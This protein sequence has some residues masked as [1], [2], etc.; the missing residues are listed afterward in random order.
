MLLKRRRNTT[1]ENV[2]DLNSRLQES[3]SRENAYD[4][5]IRT[6]LVLVKEF[7]LDIA[8]LKTDRFYAS[9]DAFSEKF[10]S[11]Q[12]SNRIL[13]HF[14][15]QK[16]VIAGFIDQQKRYLDE[17]EAELRN[18][19]DLLTRAMVSVDSEN[20]AYH[21]K[22]LQQSEKMEQITRL[23]DI[24]KI[25]AALEIEVATLRET[26]RNK[27]VGEQAR[28]QS[29]SGQVKSLR[30]E[31]E[32]AKEESQRDGLTG[33]YNRRAFDDYLQSLMER[34]LLQRQDFAILILDIDD[35]KA[36]NDTYGHP[37]GD[38][39]LL[40]MA[41]TFGHMV[42][43]DDFLARYGGEE[44]VIVL[45]GASRRNAVK[46]GKLI[47]KTVHKTRFTFDPDDRQPPLSLTVSI[48]A[49]AY[50]RGDTAASLLSRADQAL[51][52]AKQAGKNGVMT[53]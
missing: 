31:L 36:V 1:E 8:E 17:R 43:S 16:P 22:I 23:D 15:K 47:C 29:L 9:M 30:Q 39:V 41:E 3:E 45:P 27:Q 53:S 19:I 51:Y 40:A 46:K 5:V 28:I 33:I 38:R 7:A 13:P 24:R 42:R 52:K 4:T 14:E 6:L 32:M 49:T 34:N 12:K 21:H 35:F 2:V 10:F 11:Q 26:V 18:I 44:F 37:V 25:K 20:D 50:K 48:G